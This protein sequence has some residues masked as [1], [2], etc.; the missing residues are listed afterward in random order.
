MTF[1]LGFPRVVIQEQSLTAPHIYRKAAPHKD[2]LSFPL[3][4]AMVFI[5]PGIDFLGRGA[6]FLCT[7]TSIV[8]GLNKCVGLNLPPCILIMGTLFSFPTYA[9]ICIVVTQIFKPREAARLGACI[10]PMQGKWIGNIDVLRSMNEKFEFGYP[11][12]SSSCQE[13]SDINTITPPGVGLEE[14]VEQKGFLVNLRALWSDMIFTTSPEH[15]KT[16]LATDFHNYVKGLSC[17]DL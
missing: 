8:V 6:I 12:A 4:V 9:T 16:I 15:I 11:G 7:P 14:L 3:E 5:T 13:S 17:G 1:Y 10:V 2:I